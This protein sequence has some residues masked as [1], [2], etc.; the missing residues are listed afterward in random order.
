MSRVSERQGV[1][2]ERG[3]KQSK[4]WNEGGKDREKLRREGWREVVL[5]GMS[6]FWWRRE[7]SRGRCCMVISS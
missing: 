3:E 7:R 6:L 2:E 4:Q 1:G 5:S